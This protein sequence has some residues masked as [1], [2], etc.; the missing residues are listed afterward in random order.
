MVMIGLFVVFI[1]G[2][3]GA[4]ELAGGGNGLLVG[5]ATGGDGSRL[6]GSTAGHMNLL[7]QGYLYPELV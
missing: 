7:F 3:C 2:R 1:V 5:G 6:V 4:S